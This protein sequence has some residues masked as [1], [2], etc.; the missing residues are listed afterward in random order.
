M[1]SDKFLPKIPA[2]AFTAE[3]ET[4]GGV[5]SGASGFVPFYITEK[6]ASPVSP[7]TASVTLTQKIPVNAIIECVAIKSIGAVTGAS[8]GTNLGVGTVADPDLIAKPANSTLTAGAEVV[9]AGTGLSATNFVA[10]GDLV[11]TS[12]NSGGS[13]T[14]TFSF[15]E[16]DIVISG[17]RFVGFGS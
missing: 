6:L 10:G 13:L 4:N 16:L 9:I 11:L 12:T 2:V 15:T 8:S 5:Q 3:G 1:S 14:G 17:R 7:A